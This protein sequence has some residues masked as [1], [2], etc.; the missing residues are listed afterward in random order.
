[1]AAHSSSLAWRIPWTEEPRRLQSMGLQEWNTT[2]QLS[3][4]I[5]NSHAQLSFGFQGWSICRR[6]RKH[7]RMDTA[8]YLYLENF[9]ILLFFQVEKIF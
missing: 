7:R 4:P 8:D 2:E 6:E 1:M 9:L 5:F 3:L